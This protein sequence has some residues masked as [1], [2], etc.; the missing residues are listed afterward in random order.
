MNNNKL[1]D[2]VKNGG[3]FTISY[4]RN[5]FSGTISQFALMCK[6]FVDF[7]H[8][9]NKHFGMAVYVN[10]REYEIERGFKPVLLNAV[11]EDK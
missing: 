7:K 10:G 5:T 8:L 3:V 2:I 6:S 1:L 11:Q 9:P 4:G